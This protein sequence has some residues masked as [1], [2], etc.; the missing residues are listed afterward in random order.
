M[1]KSKNYLFLLFAVGIFSS[2]MNNED[3]PPTPEIAFKDFVKRG[4][5]SAD[6]II[7]FKDGD[8]D[9]GLNPWDTTDE[10]SVTGPYYYNLVMKYYY[11]KPDGNFER[12]V[13]PGND[14]LEYKYRVPDLRLRGQNKALAGEIMVNML[15]PF[16]VPGHTAIRYDVYIYDRSLNKSNVIT[17]PEISV[18]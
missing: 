7:T 4:N 6:F 17:T 11:K 9:L 8:G 3:Y 1:L 14:T 13:L 15:A 18:P 5:D 12:Y 16:Y 10:F 2:C